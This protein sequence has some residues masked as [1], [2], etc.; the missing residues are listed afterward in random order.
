MKEYLLPEEDV[1]LLVLNKGIGEYFENVISELVRWEKD[2]QI[3]DKKNRLIKL[4]ANY[5]ITELQKLFKQN[6]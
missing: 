1:N 3:K 5:I 2:E 6:I 4:T